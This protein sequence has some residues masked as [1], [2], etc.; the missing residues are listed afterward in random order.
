MKN[1]T[2]ADLLINRIAKDEIDTIFGLTGGGIMYL[3]DSIAR[4]EKVRLIPTSWEFAGL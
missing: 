4:S 2:I 1:I 3:I